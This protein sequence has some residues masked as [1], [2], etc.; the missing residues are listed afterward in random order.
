[1]EPSPTPFFRRLLSAALALAFMVDSPVYSQSTP[2]EPPPMAPAEFAPDYVNQTWK[3]SIR[4]DTLH[5]WLYSVEESPDLATW[6]LVPNSYFYGNGTQMKCYVCDGP[7]PPTQ[8]APTNGSGTTNSWPMQVQHFSLTL[9]MKSG[10]PYSGYFLQ[11]ESADPES[12]DAWQTDILEPLPPQQEGNRYFSML[13]WADPTN[14]LVYWVDVHVIITAAAPPAAGNINPPAPGEPDLIIYENIKPQL[15]ARLLT[16]VSATPPSNTPSISKFA[17]IRRTA[18]DSNGNGYPDWYEYLYFGENAVF[19]TEGSPDYVD[20][21]LDTDGDGFT[22]AEEITAGTDPT[23]PSSHPPETTYLVVATKRINFGGIIFGSMW[24]LGNSLR[25]IITKEIS[26]QAPFTQSTLGA[27]YSSASAMEADLLSPAFPDSPDKMP[28][29]T[30]AEIAAVTGIKLIGGYQKSPNSPLMASGSAAEAN[31]WLVHKPIS[32]VPIKRNYIL[33]TTKSTLSNQDDPDITFE[34]I[35]LI[36]PGGQSK[37]TATELVA[38]PST[39]EPEADDEKMTVSISRELI[40]MEISANFGFEWEVSGKTRVDE[41]LEAMADEASEFSQVGADYSIFYIKG[42]PMGSNVGIPAG[43]NNAE[44]FWAVQTAHSQA[45]LKDA[46]ASTPY[47]VFE[48]HSNFG[49]G[50][51]FDNSPVTISDFMN[52]SN[53]TAGISWDYLHQEYPQLGIIPEALVRPTQMNYLVFPG[54][55]DSLRFPNS[56]DVRTGEIFHYTNHPT[57][58]TRRH[59]TVSGTPMLI[60]FAGKADLPPLGYRAFFYNACFTA[61]DY[62]DVFPRGRFIGS[63]DLIF[64]DLKA[65]EAYVTGLISGKG[66]E[67]I[68]NDINRTHH[69]RTDDGNKNPYRRINH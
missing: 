22:D 15:I 58:N 42:K 66:W 48:G 16:P 26:W 53:P 23:S 29:K 19:A 50:P 1:M 21:S 20:G 44:Y 8:A 13:E 40:A 68:M 14:H 67:G 37:T 62:S 7:A 18:I 30:E 69:D 39:V 4:T 61:R 47:V 25:H 6:T 9:R 56:N 27:G 28:L 10:F 11:R 2:G 33:K 51:A 36:I 32:S 24:G 49:L 45:A 52:I 57:T 59:Y 17:R 54:E 46:L 41:K 64:P 34:V 5:G 55:P 3:W 38:L 63:T 35:T 65:T 31:Y 60:V 43:T 12:P